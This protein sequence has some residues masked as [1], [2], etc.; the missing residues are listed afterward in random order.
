[1]LPSRHRNV[2]K[3]E[4]LLSSTP[5]TQSDAWQALTQFVQSEQNKLYDSPYLEVAHY[6]EDLEHVCDTLNT[7]TSRERAPVSTTRMAVHPPVQDAASSLPYYNTTSNALPAVASALTSP[8]AVQNDAHSHEAPPMS[9]KDARKAEKDARKAAKKAKK[10][11]KKAK[12]EA[13]KLA[14]KAK[15]EVKHKLQHT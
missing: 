3:V 5:L 7:M 13:K 2:V 10:E 1:M 4:R 14:K 11:A 8:L 9:S 6:L 15:K 12:K